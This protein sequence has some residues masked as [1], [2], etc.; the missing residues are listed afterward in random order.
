M[1]KVT[2]LNFVDILVFLV[3]NAKFWA[4]RHFVHQGSV[5]SVGSLGSV[6][7]W[8][9]RVTGPCRSRKHLGLQGGGAG[10]HLGLQGGTWSDYG[11]R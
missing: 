9:S 7:T 6:G 3:F 2:K 10:G 4:I 1:L 11:S 5:G 8:G